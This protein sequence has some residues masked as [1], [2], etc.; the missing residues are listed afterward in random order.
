MDK[1]RKV[2]AVCKACGAKLSADNVDRSGG[3]KVC[4]F[5]YEPVTVSK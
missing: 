3:V 2:V 1:F 4:A 5:C